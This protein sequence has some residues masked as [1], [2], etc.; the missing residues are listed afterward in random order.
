MFTMGEFTIGVHRSLVVVVLVAGVL[1]LS[2]GSAAAQAQPPLCAGLPVTIDAA[3]FGGVVTGT[4]GDDVI[5]GTP[6]DDLIAAAAGNDTV[7]GLGGNDAIWG[8]DGDDV[9]LGGGGDDR[10]RGG[11][12]DDLLRG[13]DGADDLN[14]GR[15]ADVVYGDGG[16]DSSLRGGTGDD[17]VDGG[18]GDDA[19]VAGNGGRDIVRGGDGNE[20]LISGGP[21]PDLLWGDRGD[22]LLKGLGGADKIFGGAGDDEL[23]G[24]RQPDLLD[25]GDGTDV[26]NGGQELAQARACETE[27]NAERAD[28][29]ILR[30]GGHLRLAQWQ[31]PLQANPYQ[32]YAVADAL[33]SSLALEPLAS[34]SPDGEL[35]ARLASEIPTVAN[36]GISP[37]RRSVTWTLAPG[38]RWSDGSLLSAG[39]VVFTWTY[40]VNEATGCTSEVFRYVESVIALDDVTVRVS[41]TQPTSYPFVPFVGHRSPI[42]QQAQFAPCIGV[43]AS[44]CVAQNE[45]PI[46]TG[47]F[48]LTSSTTAEWNTE[49]RDFAAGKPAFA[50]V[51]IVPGQGPVGAANEVLQDAIADFAWRVEVDPDAIAS[52]L[53]AQ[54]G[55]IEP[56]FAGLVEHIN[57]NQTNNRVAGPT[58]SEYLSGTNPHPILFR[59]RELVRALS[60]A[61]DRSR[62]IGGGAWTSRP[63]CDIWPVGQQA[64][65]QQGTGPGEWC[66]TQDLGEARRILDEAGY[67]DADG[68]GIRE[69]PDGLPLVFDFVTST[70]SWRQANQAVIKANWADIGVDVEMR[71]LPAAEFFDNAN[72]DDSLWRF[73]SD[74]SMLTNGP[75]SPDAASYLVNW[76]TDEIPTSFNGWSGFNL[77]RF[78]SSDY[79]RIIDDMSQVAFGDPARDELV[80]R[81]NDVLTSEAAVIIPLVERGMIAAVSNVMAGVGPVNG[82]W[83]S[84][85]WNVADW[86]R[87]DR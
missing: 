79:D 28:P 4:D 72:I 11:D 68:D 71:H 9:L 16:A 55:R 25:G 74:F 10:I 60:L 51:E 27:V 32:S 59:N 36:G 85:Y 50:T 8:Q 23:R 45:R 57:V 48:V 77:P 54:H 67:R 65:A 5:L 82:W 12:G 38:V 52:L 15:D 64:G 78:D 63:T 66:L 61:I 33:A 6:G 86:T 19:L 24:G 42:L 20:A 76:T 39:D 81:A 75:D 70:L 80:A 46:G 14:G 62:I 3:A 83:D 29:L 43:D 30:S 34:I 40:C 44:M 22:D 69:T 53:V 7:C 47:P 73:R 37:D 17:V 58:A 87:L 31:I 56:A 2:G 41:F 13:G 84:M 21:R 35:V 26:C 1:V 18:E 49:Y